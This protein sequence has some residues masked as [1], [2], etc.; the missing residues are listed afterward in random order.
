MRRKRPD[1]VRSLERPSLLSPGVIVDLNLVPED[2]ELRPDEVVL[3]H[4]PGSDAEWN[5][6]RGASFVNDSAGR[7]YYPPTAIEPGV[8]PARSGSPTGSGTISSTATRNAK[9]SLTAGGPIRAGSS[10]WLV[11]LVDQPRPGQTVTLVLPK[12]LSPRRPESL[13]QPVQGT[14]ATLS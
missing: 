8:T 12:G 10:F 14:G 3:S 11:A 1:F 4:W 2:G 7:C 9:L 13:S 6:S 5:Y